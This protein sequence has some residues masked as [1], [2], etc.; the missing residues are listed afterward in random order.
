MKPTSTDSEMKLTTVPA[1]ASQATNAIIATPSAVALARPAKSAASP[2]A[3]SASEVPSRS[4]I[5][6]VTETAVWREPQNSQNTS[7]ENRQA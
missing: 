7:P 1:R 6:E 2:P 3:M 4:E 5:A